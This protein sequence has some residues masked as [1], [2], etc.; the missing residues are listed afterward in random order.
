MGIVILAL[1]LYGPLVAVAWVKVGAIA[2]IIATLL[3]ALAAFVGSQPGARQILR[4][5]TDTW[6]TRPRK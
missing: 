2:G 6:R 1:L 3:F 5:S 4:A